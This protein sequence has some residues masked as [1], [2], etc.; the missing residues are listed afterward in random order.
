MRS[1]VV[2]PS[3][4]ELGFFLQHRVHDDCEATRQS[5]LSLSDGDG[6]VTSSVFTVLYSAFLLSS[7][8]LRGEA[9]LDKFK[10]LANQSRAS[11]HPFLARCD[12]A[13]ALTAVTQANERQSLFLVLMFPPSSRSYR[14]VD[15]INSVSTAI[16]SSLP[17]TRGSFGIP[18]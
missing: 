10:R 1:P 18:T 14:T 13:A 3:R 16:S 2:W 9:G 11:K 7:T 5:D 6:L 12:N 4:R 8:H 15:L 17:E